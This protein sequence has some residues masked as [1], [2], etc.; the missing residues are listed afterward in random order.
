MQVFSRLIGTLSWGGGGGGGREKVT[1]ACLQAL[2][3]GV[4]PK[5][6]NDTHIVLIPKKV[7]SEKVADMRPIA[8]SNILY[9]ILAKT[10]ANIMKSILTEVISESQS[11]FVPS[12]LIIDNIMIAFEMCH[13]I[14]CKKQG[15]VGLAA[16]K[17]D[18][19]KTHDLV[20]WLF[21]EEIMHKLGFHDKWVSLVMQC[22]RTVQYWILHNGV[23]SDSFTLEQG[24]RQS[25]PLS[26]YLLILCAQGLSCALR[27]L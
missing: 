5:N 18:M 8:L 3:S 6:W 11:A 9:K 7:S 4:I 23:E 22:V 24:L 26:P 20:E 12:K 25:E 10:L 19:S 15:K 13:H 14:K 1:D 16:M 17:T 2:N 27:D 21:L